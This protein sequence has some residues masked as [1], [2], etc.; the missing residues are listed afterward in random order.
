MTQKGAHETGQPC[1]GSALSAPAA[2][3]QP[4]Q[5]VCLLRPH[6]LPHQQAAAGAQGDG[7]EVGQHLWRRLHLQHRNIL[8]RVALHS[9]GQQRAQVEGDGQAASSARWAYSLSRSTRTLRDS[10][11]LRGAGPLGALTPMILAG[12]VDWS[13]SDTRTSEAPRMT[14]KLVA[15]WPRPSHTN[16]LPWP[17]GKEQWGQ[18]W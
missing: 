17:A 8:R 7:L 15:M 6:L 5:S 18:G 12:H 2:Q 10:D 3:R 11:R 4:S 1:P 9:V 16:P 14:W 13:M